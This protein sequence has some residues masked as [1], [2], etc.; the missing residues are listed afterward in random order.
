M[1]HAI[2]ASQA[3]ATGALRALFSAFPADRGDGAGLA[4]TYL[5]AIEGYSLKA[6]EGAVKRIIRGEADGIDK[7]FLPTPA[8]VGNLAAY[9]EKLYVPVEPRAA[10]P[11]PGDAVLT[12]EEWDRRGRQAQAARERFGIE[13]RGGETIVDREAIPEARRAE[14]DRTVS[15]VAARLKEEGLPALSDEALSII[16][17]NPRMSDEEYRAFMDKTERAA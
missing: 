13:K 14:L 4:A 10:L 2:P 12:E 8:Q 15:T 9:V 17:A 6:I 3:E 16:G 5:I 7:R 1:R 11:A